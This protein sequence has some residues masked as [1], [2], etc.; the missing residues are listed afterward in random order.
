MASATEMADSIAGELLAAINA[1]NYKQII[2]FLPAEYGMSKDIF[3]KTMLSVKYTLDVDRWLDG[4]FMN[5]NAL[6]ELF[7]VYSGHT[8]FQVCK[9][10]L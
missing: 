9:S 5:A 8:A 6:F 10:M 7:G 3:P 4:S 1:K 2:A